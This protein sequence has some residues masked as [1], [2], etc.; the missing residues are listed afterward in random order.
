MA[1]F[2]KRMFLFSIVTPFLIACNSESEL[3][4]RYIRTTPTDFERQ[5]GMNTAIELIP[6]NEKTITVI[7][8]NSYGNLSYTGILD[9]QR[10]IVDD[11]YIMTLKQDILQVKI[12]DSPEQSFDFRREK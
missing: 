12:P 1:S 9:G 4:G 11:D 5:H 10:L 7:M 6:Q 8:E 3:K 2:I